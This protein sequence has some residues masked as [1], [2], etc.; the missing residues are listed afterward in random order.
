MTRVEMKT[1]S[2]PHQEEEGRIKGVVKISRAAGEPHR[3]LSPPKP[4]LHPAAVTQTFWASGEEEEEIEA[5]SFSCVISLESSVQV[6]V[7]AFLICSFQLLRLSPHL[8]SSSVPTKHFQPFAESF[9]LWLCSERERK[10]K[11]IMIP[12]QEIDSGCLN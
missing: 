10:V 3:W 8:I 5:V 1:K 12:R 6:S 7:P 2:E 4:H 9:S 11:Y